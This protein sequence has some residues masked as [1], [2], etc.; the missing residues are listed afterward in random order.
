MRVAFNAAFE[1]GVRNI[2]NAS[3]ALAEAQRQLSSGRR[4]DRIAGREC[5]TRDHSRFQS[6]T[7]VNAYTKYTK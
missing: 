1:D 7:S 2:N 4:I 3:A 6:R 5:F